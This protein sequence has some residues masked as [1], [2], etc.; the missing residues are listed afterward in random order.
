MLRIFSHKKQDMEGE[1]LP[2]SL[3]L[4]FCYHLVVLS[5]HLLGPPQQQLSTT[6]PGTN[7]SKSLSVFLQRVNSMILLNNFAL[8]LPEPEIQENQNLN[9]LYLLHISLRTCCMLLEC[10]CHNHLLKL[11]Q[12]KHRENRR[13]TKGPSTKDVATLNNQW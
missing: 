6:S 1:F 13:N 5:E 9:I 12:L 2:Q 4:S 8:H 10:E 7:G 3:C 11:F